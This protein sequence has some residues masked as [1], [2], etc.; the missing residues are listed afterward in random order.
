MAYSYTTTIKPGYIKL[1]SIYLGAEAVRQNKLVAG[2][3]V[4]VLVEGAPEISAQGT[5][6]TGHGLSG[7][8]K[9][10]AA[11]K[12]RAGDSITFKISQTGGPI[13]IV[14]NS[15]EPTPKVPAA[16][17]DG[18]V[19]ERQKL[20]HMHIEPF[21]AENLDNWEPENETDIY[22]ALGVLQEHTDFEYC[23]ATSKPLLD[24]LGATYNDK[25]DAILIDRVTDQY[26]MAEMKK[27]SSAF[28][29]NHKPE[30]VDVL[31]CWVDDET[32]RE[33]LPKR[34]VALSKVAR[35]ALAQRLENEDDE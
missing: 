33:K 35:A 34:V 11:L 7:M 21:R 19:F 26:L 15:A 5:L 27:Y 22:L 20:K 2:E 17:P 29:G 18:T 31:V 32:D 1:R 23:C 8:A 13:V 10:Y 6:S 12:L 16:A 4:T 30:D 3:R 24:L 28:K 25:P 9:V 14:P